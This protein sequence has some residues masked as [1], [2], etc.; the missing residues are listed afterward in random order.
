MH[1]PH[2]SKHCKDRNKIVR[3]I[4]NK[5]DKNKQNIVNKVLEFMHTTI[6]IKKYIT[7]KIRDENLVQTLL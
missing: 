4:Y 6:G 2:E 1:L 5:K 3:L 7:Y